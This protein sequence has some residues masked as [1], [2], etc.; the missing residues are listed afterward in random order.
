MF[1]SFLEVS[2]LN[3]TDIFHSRTSTQI[4]M[5]QTNYQK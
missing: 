4:R 1:V 2:F 3:M 5:N